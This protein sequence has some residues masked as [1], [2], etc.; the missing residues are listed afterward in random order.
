MK[1][2]RIHCFPI[3]VL[4]G[5]LCLLAFS[6]L[7]KAGATPLQFIE[8]LTHHA[9]VSVNERGEITML[10]TGDDPQL[11]FIIDPELEVPEDHFML[12][13]EYFCPDGV[14][15]TEV[16]YARSLEQGWS[17]HRSIEG[18]R[19][20]IAEAWQPFAINL[21]HGSRGEWTP[22]QRAIRID[23][24][25]E[26]DLHMQVR[27]LHLRAPTEAE[28]RSAEE[29]E[30]I[31]QEK[32]EKASQID[33]YLERDDWSATV[34]SVVVDQREITV[35]GTW[36]GPMEEPAHL[37]KFAPHEDPWS[38]E[39]GTVVQAITT[40]TDSFS[41]TIPRFKEQRDRLAYRFAMARQTGDTLKLLSRAAWADDVREAA[42]REMPRLRPE[43]KK[44]MA[45]ALYGPKR[46]I[47]EKDLTELG[48]TAA[49][50]NMQLGGLLS[51]GEEV[52]EY[53][54]Q[55]RTWLFN[56]KEL[57]E[58]DRTIGKLTEMD[59]VV[60]GILLVNRESGLL[61]HPEYDPAGIYGMANLTTQ[62]AADTYRAIISFLAE[63]YSRPDQRY[64]WVTHWIVFNEVDYGWVWTNMGEQP[65][66]VYMDAYDKAMRITWLETRRY[67]PTAEVFISL[68]HN[69][70]YNPTDRYRTYAPRA[71]IDRMALYSRTTGDYGWGVAQHPYPQSLLRPRTWEDHLPTASFDT[72]YI[73]PRNIEVLDAY[74]HQDHLLYEEEAR[75]V[76]LSE[77]G[78]HTPDYSEQS[79][80]DKA[81]AIA[82][83]WAKIT[84]LESVES[85]HYHRW[86][87]HPLEGGLKVGLR[88]LPEPGKP[89]GERKE[90]AF[91]VMGALETDREAEAIAPFKEIL[92][93]NNWEEVRI[94]LEEIQRD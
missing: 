90:P 14:D 45:G 57:E 15:S 87:D 54:H 59:I 42:E 26:P 81:A 4:G 67:N 50:V 83:T 72:P 11:I 71:L 91:S 47:F 92:G 62:E 77:Q 27:N 16:F 73:T 24:G 68:T 48:M 58:F 85:F 64:G 51:P 3:K 21:D 19:L 38:D 44:G 49:T 84:P 76:L 70:D 8:G 75:T 52:I 25:R 43:N 29:A 66:S 69:W 65:M 33:L 46:E 23:F 12:A 35:S 36:N 86:V 31:L 89:H 10:T 93:I 55:G 32:R 9:E 40:E 7:L 5:L 41:L 82:Y 61:L 6:S 28:M 13:F 22:E 74:M 60:S 20:P 17:P 34:T 39:G 94:P 80:L 56:K 78:F 18:G 79:M 1:T 30:A 88:T 2:N 37:V 53:S 63:R